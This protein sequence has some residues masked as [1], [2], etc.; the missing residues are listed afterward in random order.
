V[1]YEWAKYRC[2]VR[3]VDK[4]TGMRFWPAISANTAQVLKEKTGEVK[5]REPN[6]KKALD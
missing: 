6:G 3:E 2:P 4:M 1:D 5:V